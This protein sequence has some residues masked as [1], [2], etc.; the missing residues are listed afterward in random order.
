[1]Q[2][3]INDHPN[4]EDEEFNLLEQRIKPSYQ[5]KG[6]MCLNCTNW[7]ADCSGHSF[8]DMPIVAK[9]GKTV[10]VKCTEFRKVEK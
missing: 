3:T 10:I 1:M 9:L 5:P 8:K 6:S 4:I 7:K 2:S